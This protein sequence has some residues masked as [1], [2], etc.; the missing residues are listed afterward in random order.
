MRGLGGGSIVTTPPAG[1]IAVQRNDDDEIMFL[2]LNADLLLAE[3]VA[4]D[5]G[6]GCKKR[7]R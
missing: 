4:A 2:N 3:P 1:F 6:D 5:D 7:R